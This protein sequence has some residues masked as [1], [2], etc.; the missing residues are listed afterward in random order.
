MN[1]ELSVIITA[2]DRENQDLKDLLLSISD[3]SYKNYEVD[4]VTEGDSESAKAIGVRRARGEF[5]CILSS[6]NF[7]NETTFFEKHIAV[8]KAIPIATGAYPFRYFYHLDDTLLN[9]YF[10][11]MGCNDP[12]PYYLGKCDKVPYNRDIPYRMVKDQVPTIGDNG[13]FIRKELLLKADL[14]HYYHIDVCEDLRRKGYTFYVLTDSYIWHKTAKEFWAFFGKRLKYADKFAVSQ[15]RWQMVRPK[16]IPR[17]IWFIVCTL[18]C[19]QPLWISL[20]G[21]R[22]IKD[23]AWFL[24]LPVCWVTLGVYGIW[25]IRRFLFSSVRLIEKKV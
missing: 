19:V 4:V 22:K 25:V 17:L 13:F 23:K 20:V 15:R 3:Q 2:K 5:I 8:L 6:D 1:P 24:H 11:L 21:Y 14:D 10:A 7:L 9:R 18:T 12:I 16:D